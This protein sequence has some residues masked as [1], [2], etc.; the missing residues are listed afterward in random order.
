MKRSPKNIRR[1]PLFNN[2]AGIHNDNTIG[3]SGKM[4]G[5]WLIIQECRAISLAISHSRARISACSDASSLLVGS[6]AITRL[7]GMLIA[8]AIR[9]LP[10]TSTKLVR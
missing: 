4:V 10:L 5:S 3:K 8:C 7:G 6:S 9:P 2:L 1:L